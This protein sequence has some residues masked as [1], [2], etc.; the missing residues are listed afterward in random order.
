MPIQNLSKLRDLFVEQSTDISKRL[1]YVR[2]SYHSGV[3]WGSMRLGEEAI[4]NLLLLDLFEQ[5]SRV[6]HF[7]QTSRPEESISGVDFELWIGSRIKGWL[8]FAIQAKKIDVKTKTGRYSSLKHETPSGEQ[9]IDLLEN[10][11]RVNCAAPL[12]CLY[13]HTADATEPDHWHCCTE[14]A[15]LKELGCTVTPS[16]NIS[17]AI[18][19]WGGRNFTSIHKNEGSL[20]LKC[21]LCPKRIWDLFDDIPENECMEQAVEM[22]DLFNPSSY[23]H[24]TLSRALLENLEADI[25]NERGGS[26]TF[27]PA[28]AYLDAEDA[29]AGS[30]LRNRRGVGRP[31]AVAVID[32]DHL[33]RG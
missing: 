14:P 5:G 20:P 6:F 15:D 32:I 28:D 19:E 16:R 24:K 31:K 12:Y 30:N 3:D 10:Y 27:L 1:G 7:K 13:N 8:R 17:K 4:T 9:Q 25:E 26:R 21:L 11:A 29:M 33:G 2:E 23:Y 22:P 18:D